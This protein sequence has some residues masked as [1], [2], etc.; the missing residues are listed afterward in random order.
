MLRAIAKTLASTHRHPA[1]IAFHAAG[2]PLYIYGI[3]MILGH[4]MDAGT[5][6]LFGILLW[7]L[8][9]SMF[10]AGHAIEGNVKSVTPVLIARL[11]C[12]SLHRHFAKKRIPILH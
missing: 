2:L 10:V 5:D 1:N 4:F 7:G 11:V 8:A 9:I 12:R 6:S 3:A